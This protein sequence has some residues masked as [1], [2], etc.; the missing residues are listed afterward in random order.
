M[1]CDINNNIINLL[2]QFKTISCF[3]AVSYFNFHTYFNIIFIV[4]L[5]TFVSF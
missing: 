4:R 1:K 2:I 3:A 5:Q